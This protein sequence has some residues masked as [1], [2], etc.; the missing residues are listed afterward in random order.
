MSTK[1]GSSILRVETFHS[2]YLNNDR[3]LFIYLPPSYQQDPNKRYPVLYMH[4]GQN[5]FHPAFNGYSWNVHAAADMLIAEQRME[6][7]IIVGI[8]NMGMERADEFTHDLEGVR[9]QDDKFAIQP[10]GHQYER[11]LI[12]EVKPY[13]DALF[14]TRP[15]PEHSALMGSS[16][17]GQVTYHIGLRR[18]DVFSMLGI[19]SPYLYCVYPETLE[20]VP[21]YHTFTAKQSTKKIWI[22]LGSREGLLVMEKHVREAAEKLLSIGYKADDELVYLYEPEASHVEKDWAARVSAPLLH[23]FG[24][25]GKACSLMLHGDQVVGIAGPPCRLNPIIEFDSGFK[26]SVLRAAYRVEDEH[27]A[28]VRDDGTVI[29]LRPGVTEVTVQFEGCCEASMPLRIVEELSTHVD[30]EIIVHVP[31]GTPQDLKL[32]AWFPLTYDPNT[33]AYATRLRIPLHTDWL[34]QVSRADGIVEVDGAGARVERS[35]K[36]E[37]DATLVIHVERWSGQ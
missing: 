13:V 19:V 11:F 12:E 1:Y 3:E 24:K 9:Y 26:M 18:P 6:E 4:D 35:Y 31:P 28:Q 33:D 34:F 14:R 22:D 21:L 15:E 16:R 2:E 30:L 5:I 10:R 37:Q 25:R 8:P 17:G 7:I 27:I 23:F 20:E 36:A 29:P 32:Y